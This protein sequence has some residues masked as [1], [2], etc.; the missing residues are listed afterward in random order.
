MNKDNK[1]L[2]LQQYGLSI[3]GGMYE[4]KLSTGRVIIAENFLGNWIT[5][6]T[7]H[8]ID[9]EYEITHF[10][11]LESPNVKYIDLTEFETV[12]IAVNTFYED[13]LNACKVPKKY[14][15]K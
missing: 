11:K 12:V 6:E 8:L 4:I 2:E 9:E 1:W 3:P 7:L 15:T 10:R 5:D 14:L 13:M